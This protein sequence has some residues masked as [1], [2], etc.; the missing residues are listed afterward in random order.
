MIHTDIAKS[1]ELANVSPARNHSYFQK[2]VSEPTGVI[3]V[4]AYRYGKGEKTHMCQ[5]DIS[6]KMGGIQKVLKYIQYTKIP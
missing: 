5:Q 3:P 4:L 6:E 2:G 1:F